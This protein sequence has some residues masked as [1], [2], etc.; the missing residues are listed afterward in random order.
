M[1]AVMFRIK[2]VYEPAPPQ[3]G[4]RV[5]VDGLGPPGITKAEARFDHCVK[6]VVPS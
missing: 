6:E 2:R 3:D 5:L 4:Y 1:G